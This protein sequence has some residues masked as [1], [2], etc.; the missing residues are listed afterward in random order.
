MRTA[1]DHTDHE[2]LSA[3]M[4]DDRYAF[5]V[6]YRKYVRYL[7]NYLR[8]NIAAKEDCEEIIQEIFEALWTK[9][10]TLRIQTSLK[11]KSIGSAR[12]NDHHKKGLFRG[13]IIHVAQHLHACTPLP[14]TLVHESPM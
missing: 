4:E 8:K 3:L 7:F 13:K 12:E 2:L 9:R 6:I 5:E 10:S 11:A 1:S 14:Y